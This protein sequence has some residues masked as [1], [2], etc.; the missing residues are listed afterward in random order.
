MSQSPN[1]SIMMSLTSLSSSLLSSDSGSDS[2]SD[3]DC[4]VAVCG[5]SGEELSGKL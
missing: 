3:D 4:T 1:T 5:V 2:D